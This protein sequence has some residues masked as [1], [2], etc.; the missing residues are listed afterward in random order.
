MAAIL[1]RSFAGSSK[2]GRTRDLVLERLRLSQDRFGGQNQTFRTLSRYYFNL[3]PHIRARDNDR[4]TSGR[5]NEYPDLFV[6]RS[7]TSVEAAVPP[8]VFSVVGGNPPVKVY[9]RKQEY[10]RSSEAVE[11]MIAYDWER[12][13]VLHKSIE[14]AKQIFKYG[15]GIAQIG[16]KRDAFEVKRPYDVTEAYGFKG[17]DDEGRPKPLTRTRTHKRPDEVVRFEGPTL[18]PVSVFNAHPDVNDRQESGG[19]GSGRRASAGD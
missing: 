18:D 15:T 17:F 9:S 14:V 1:Q 10:Q 13:D 6:P 7:F 8:W 5:R 4:P 11:N 12:S 19:D 16:Y 3:S 2:E